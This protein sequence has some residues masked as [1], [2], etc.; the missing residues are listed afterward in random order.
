VVPTS[1]TFSE[2][3]HDE[4]DDLLRVGR[5]SWASCRRRKGLILAVTLLGLGLAVFYLAWRGDSYT[6]S[7]RILVDNRVL[8]LAQQDAIYSISSLTSQLMQSQV[9]I[10]R[11]ENIARRVIDQLGLLRSPDFGAQAQAQANAKADP[12]PGSATEDAR[13]LRR[14]LDMFQKRLSVDQVGQSYV[15]EVRVRAGD[16]QRAAEIANGL[17]AAYLDDQATANATVAQSASGWLR[18]RMRALGTSAR[19][20]TAAT[21][22]NEK[23]GPRAAIIL[24]FAALC[25]LTIGGGL[26]FSRDIFD[27]KLRTRNAVQTASGT[28]CFGVLPAIRQRASLFKGWG[29]RKEP[30]A[31]EGE[32]LVADDASLAWAIDRPRSMFAHSLRRTRAEL[33][34]DE[35]AAPAVIGISSALPREGKTVVAANLARLAALWGKRVLLIDAAPYNA[36]LTKLLA[37]QAKHGLGDALNSVA[38]DEI[39]LRDRWTE[40]RFLPAARHDAAAATEPG[41]TASALERVLP[42]IKS[43]YDLVIIDLPPLTPVSDVQELAHLLDKVLLVVEW[44]RCTNEELTAALARAGLARRKLAGAVLNKADPQSLRS[45]ADDPEASGS[46]E[47]ADYLD[48]KER[49]RPNPLP[50]AVRR[51]EARPAATPAPA[52]DRAQTLL[53]SIH[54]GRGKAAALEEGSKGNG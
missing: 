7:S 20:L 6:A 35:M 16:P 18:D 1:F 15:I 29:R 28:E 53:R 39:V 22:P 43:Q 9:E 40:M 32:R 8:A 45:Y 37:P 49:P 47:F 19:V 38:L 10:L 31:P 26:A 14:A 24:G 13:A 51:E 48:D 34:S 36:Q 5:L 42:Q 30:T 17:V 4:L 27:R 2:P 46:A 41:V 21:A 3:R 44:G 11:S 54:A 33:L 50:A 23:D 12:P 52:Q 25:G